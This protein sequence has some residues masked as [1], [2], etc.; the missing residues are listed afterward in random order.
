MAVKHQNFKHSKKIERATT[1]EL[2][3][4][5]LMLRCV[6]LGLSVNELDNYEIGMIYDMLTEQANDSYDYPLKPR[7]EDFDRFKK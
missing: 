3:T 5:L 6:G 4:P 2:N 1:R 7:Q